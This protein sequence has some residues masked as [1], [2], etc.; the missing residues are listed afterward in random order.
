MKS[1]LKIITLIIVAILL[2][3]SCAYLIVQFVRAKN[4]TIQNPVLT[5]EIENYGNI[6]IE[7]YP[8]YAPNTVKNIIKL[9]EKGYYDGNLERH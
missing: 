2:I 8:E 4:Q 1:K 9:A 5:L 6:K 3:T 7:L